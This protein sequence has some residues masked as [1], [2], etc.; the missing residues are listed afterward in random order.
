MTAHEVPLLEQPEVRGRSRHELADGI[1]PEHAPDHGGGLQ[2]RL[3]GP[4]QQVDARGEHGLDGVRHGETGR[5]LTERPAAVFAAEH[6]PVDQRGDQLLDKERV[7][8]GPFG[9]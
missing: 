5:E 1:V 3:L 9:D 4:G 6:A 2:R 8:L 7:P